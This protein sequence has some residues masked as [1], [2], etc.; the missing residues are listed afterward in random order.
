MFISSFDITSHVFPNPKILS[1]IP[2][3]ATDAAAVNPNEIKEHLA[4]NLITF[5]INGSSVLMV[6]Q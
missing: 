6:D 1:C 3:S 2:A 4:N 5:Y